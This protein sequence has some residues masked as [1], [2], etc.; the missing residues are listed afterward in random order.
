[1][2]VIETWTKKEFLQCM[3]DLYKEAY[4]IRPR[5]VDYESWSLQELK[6]EWKRLEVIAREE[7][8]YQD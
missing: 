2:S 6:D 4:G 7:F 1:M 3:S 8:W 5:G